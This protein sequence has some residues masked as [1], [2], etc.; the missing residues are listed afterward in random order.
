MGTASAGVSRSIPA[1]LALIAA[2]FIGFSG[3]S[4]ASGAPQ[5]FG[6]ADDLGSIVGRS[7][8]GDVIRLKAGRYAVSD[9]RIRHNLTIVGL[10][11][12]V[13]Y[14]PGN[15]RKGLLV[16]ASGVDLTVRNLT[17]EGAKSPDQNGA[18][19][20]SEGRNLRVE[21]SIFRDNE[22]GI[23]ATG[24]AN[25][26]VTVRQSSFLR[27]GHLSGYSHGI[28]QVRGTRLDIRDSMFTGT[29]GGH[30]IKTL[31]GRIDVISNSFDDAKGRTS[32]V[33]DVPAGGRA[34]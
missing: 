3:Q 19:I 11:D 32:Y 34:L 10:G 14:S 1:F 18:G 12:V 29:R 23:L 17:F 26:S 4:T 6:F 8:P 24:D 13:L 20:R 31:A 2:V 21:N 30:H 22:N 5:F 28:Y 7:S 9:L 16:P 33:L 25:G 15:V 27:N